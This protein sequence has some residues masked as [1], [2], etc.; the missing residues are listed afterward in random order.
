MARQLDHVSGERHGIV[1]TAKVVEV[2]RE[3]LV[4]VGE[5]MNL[6]RQHTVAHHVGMVHP[7]AGLLLPGGVVVALELRVNV[8]G[9]VPHVRD[10]G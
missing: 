5:V 3:P 2:A 10:A 4:V 1:G 8:A 7:G 9:H 6:V